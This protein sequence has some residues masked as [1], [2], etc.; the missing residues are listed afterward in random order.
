MSIKDVADVCEK[1]TM[2]MNI[3]VLKKCTTY[4]E[5]STHKNVKH[6]FKKMLKSYKNVPK[7]V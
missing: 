2:F 7:R 1:F 4:M 3:V 5:T 6:L